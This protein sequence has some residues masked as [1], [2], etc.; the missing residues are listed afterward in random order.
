MPFITEQAADVLIRPFFGDFEQI[1][2]AAW[3]DWRTGPLAHQMQ[4]KRVRANFVWNQLI[5][6]ARRQFD[7]RTNVVVET[8]KN[9]DGVLIDNRIFVRMKKGTDKLLSR[10]YPT[11]AA[12]AF[13]DPIQD[14]FGG[15]VRLELLYVL[16]DL[17][18]EIDRIVLVQRYKSNVAWAIDLLR[19]TDAQNVF[20]LPAPQP[21]RDGG[22]VADRLIKPKEDR[23]DHEQH[24]S[25]D[26]T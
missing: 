9:W 20:D 5:A 15:V 25:A 2:K 22:S 7:S 23:T 6:H 21:D 16:N 11:Q 14:L 12:L 8:I 17:E 26:G 18:T 24:R 3:S 1:V 13:H 4:H 19:P 10:N